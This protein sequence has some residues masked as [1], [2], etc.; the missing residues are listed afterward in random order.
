MLGNSPLHCR[1]QVM[2]Y[3]FHN[4]MQPPVLNE[5]AQLILEVFDLLPRESRYGGS[6][7]DTLPRRLMAA[8][9]ILNLGLRRSCA[10]WRDVALPSARP[11]E[12]KATARIAACNANC[13]QCLTN[14][15]V[16][17]LYFPGS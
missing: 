1:P 15:V 13:E 11:A 9:A 3:V 14:M 16:T 10:E 4:R 12:A 6:C 17:F 8:L 5:G 2:R 7:P